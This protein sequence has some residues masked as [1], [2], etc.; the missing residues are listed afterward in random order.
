MLRAK[1]RMQKVREEKTHLDNW[2]NNKTQPNGIPRLSIQWLLH[3]HFKKRSFL[4][5]SIVRDCRI[6][7]SSVD[8][9]IQ[10]RGGVCVSLCVCVWWC[11]VRG[12]LL[13]GQ[14]LGI[15]NSGIFQIRLSLRTLS[16]N[17]GLL[18]MPKDFRTCL[19]SGN[20][21]CACAPTW[22]F[23]HVCHRISRHC[24]GTG[25]CSKSHT[26]WGTGWAC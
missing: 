13:S 1:I 14:I 6:L 3:P 5:A 7:S 15:Y 12:C 17:R 18:I 22:K 19:P 4:G 16:L 10:W 11:G 26:Q 24:K 21:F 9:M 20:L 25:V 23:L 2:K 8:G